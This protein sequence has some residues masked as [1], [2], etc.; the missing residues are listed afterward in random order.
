MKRLSIIFTVLCAFA[1]L[2]LS[3]SGEDGQDGRPGRDGR[4]AEII[5]RVF[6]VQSRH[7]IADATAEQPGFFYYTHDIAE[8]TN[9]IYENGVV[10][11]YRD[12]GGIQYP[13]MW[14]EYFLESGSD[15]YEVLVSYYYEV[16][17]ITFRAMY[18]DFYTDGNP[19]TM[20]F[21]VVIIR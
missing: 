11:A 19:D 6:E 17:R 9:D 10:L 4:D 16:G 1:A 15:A 7:W 18:S 8:I 14:S 2:M 13:L 20:L 21:R 12:E 5:V 3:C